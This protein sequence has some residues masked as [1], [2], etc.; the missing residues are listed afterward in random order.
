MSPEE[1]FKGM[2]SHISAQAF[3]LSKRPLRLIIDHRATLLREARRQV[4]RHQNEFALLF[5][6]TYFEHW[7]NG[8]IETA[9]DWRDMAAENT[10]SLLREA[11]LRAKLTW[12]LS[13]LSVPRLKPGYV[14]RI[15]AVA[16]HRNGCVH[17][18]WLPQAGESKRDIDALVKDAERIAQ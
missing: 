11:P 3:R 16:E 8:M 9:A 18:K 13:L 1:I 15:L 4:R 5:Y 7:I 10:T 14:K 12:V 2:T 17:Y 6:A